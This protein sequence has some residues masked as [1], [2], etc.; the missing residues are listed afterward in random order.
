MSSNTAQALVSDARVPKPLHKARKPKTAP[1]KETQGRA[2][3]GAV[4]MTPCTMDEVNAALQHAATVPAARPY[5][6]YLA[7]EAIGDYG[8][9]W[10]ARKVLGIETSSDC[11]PWARLWE[12]ELDGISANLK[13]EVAEEEEMWREITLQ[14]EERMRHWREAKVQG[15]PWSA[16]CAKCGSA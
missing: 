13:K 4:D 2:E 7:L 11:Y 14:V 10:L 3:D 8:P 15:V 12:R 5:R 6:D 9:T 16:R 1:K